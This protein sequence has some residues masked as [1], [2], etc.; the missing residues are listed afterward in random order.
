MKTKEPKNSVEAFNKVLSEFSTKGLKIQNFT[1]D[2]GNEF[3]GEFSTLLEKQ[4]IKHYTHEPGTHNTLGII[5]RFNRTVRDIIRQE[6]IKNSNNNWIDHI[7]KLIK[8]YNN[9]QHRSIK[10]NPIDI[11][12]GKQSFSNQPIKV[13]EKVKQY[14]VGDTV[15]ILKKK[16]KLEKQ[17]TTYSKEI[18]I[19]TKK[20]KFS[21]RV[22]V[23]IDEKG[24]VIENSTELKYSI[25][26]NQMKEVKV[27]ISKKQTRSRT[28][29]QEEA[30]QN[31]D[32]NKQQRKLRR[33]G[34]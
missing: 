4:E 31:E 5:E 11:W 8:Q 33:E 10:S 28:R 14:E 16:G 32:T 9:S 19:I 29:G 15:R 23:Y 13:K 2:N 12:N 24:V 1:S 34:L 18:Y 7:S 21:Y 6:F 26:P 30:K 20:N 17:D 25:K 3:K 27:V 22:R